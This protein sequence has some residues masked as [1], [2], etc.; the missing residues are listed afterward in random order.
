MGREGAYNESI[1]RLE[2]LLKSGANPNILRASEYYTW[3]PSQNVSYL[4]IE[5]EISPLMIAVSIEVV[6]LLLKYGAD[7]NFQDNYGRT[8]LMI[9][10]YFASLGELRYENMFSFLIDRGA[11]VNIRDNLGRTALY[12]ALDWVRP[13]IVRILLENGASVNIEDGNRITPLQVV[14]YINPSTLAATIGLGSGKRK[15][16]KMFEEAGAVKV[17]NDK[18]IEE[19]FGDFGY[20]PLYDLGVNYGDR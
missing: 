11:D 4:S 12:Y 6:D 20:Y 8:A 13:S 5:G 16:I 15:I 18:E 14:S 3:L 17:F 10:T 1:E 19:M 2:F 7:I 9:Y